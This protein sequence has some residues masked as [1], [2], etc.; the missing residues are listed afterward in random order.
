MRKICPYDKHDIRNIIQWLNEQSDLG[1]EFKSW[2]TM[3]CKFEEYDGPRY[4]YQ[5]D[6][7]NQEEGANPEREAELTL[8]GWEY[9]ET[10][11]DRMHLYRTTNKNASISWNEQFCDFNR[12]KIRN[13]MIWRI[14]GWLVSL[15]AVILVPLSKLEFWLVELTQNDKYLAPLLMI[16]VI[17]AV[18]HFFNDDWIDFRLYKY[19]GRVSEHMPGGG[20]P[21]WGRSKVRTPLGIIQLVLLVAVLALALWVEYGKTEEYVE[22]AFVERYYRNIEQ[23]HEPF[24]EYSQLGYYWMGVSENVQEALFDQIVERYTG[25]SNY[26]GFSLF[27]KSKYDTHD[28]WTLTERVDNRFDRLLIAR[29]TKQYE[30]MGWIFAQMENDIVCLRYWEENDILPMI[31][32]L[33]RM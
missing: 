21:E 1:W 18:L 32:E 28:R 8:L 30:G 23:V 24:E 6:F 9:V 29:G 31:E 17:I 5:I 7:D 10:I 27:L 26:S 15:A 12:K 19:L 25:Y 11:S 4:Q 13:S 2:G 16:F 3:F 33:T 14:L 20:E 22:G